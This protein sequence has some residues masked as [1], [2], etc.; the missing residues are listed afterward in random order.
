ML[1][2]VVT[3]EFKRIAFQRG[4]N[5]KVVG[6]IAYRDKRGKIIRY[7]SY[8]SEER[9]LTF[10]QE[11]KG[12][13]EIEDVGLEETDEEGHDDLSGIKYLIAQQMRRL[14]E[15]NVQKF[16]IYDSEDI[17][18]TALAEEVAE[19]M[20]LYD[21]AANIPEIVFELAFEVSEECD[22]FA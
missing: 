11:D 6:D 18:C 19:A 1:V 13:E 21:A 10:W 8:N 2:H 22:W 15:K 5:E 20:N 4:F 17:D 3:E 12:L 16:D 14:L 9:I 7:K